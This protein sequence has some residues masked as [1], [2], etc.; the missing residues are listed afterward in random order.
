MTIN[1]QIRFRNFVGHM[2]ERHVLKAKKSSL[3]TTS[4]A[5]PY[6]VYSMTSVVVRY[7]HAA[8]DE[9]ITMLQNIRSAVAKC[10]H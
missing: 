10:F 6:L 2:E 1:Y 4:V 7:M 8:A 3:T 5:T 9:S